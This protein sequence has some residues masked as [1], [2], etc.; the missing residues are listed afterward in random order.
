[1]LQATR[2]EERAHTSNGTGHAR[3]EVAPKPALDLI[4][5]PR[6]GV[7]AVPGVQPPASAAPTEDRYFGLPQAFLV[8]LAPVASLAVSYTYERAYALALGAPEILVRVDAAG[9]LPTVGPAFLAL[10]FGAALLLVVSTGAFWRMMR[11]WTTLLFALRGFASVAHSRWAN[12]LL[13]FGIC[14]SL[15]FLPWALVRA[16]RVWRWAKARLERHATARRTVVELFAPFLRWS[17]DL[18]DE[19]DRR[20]RAIAVALGP[21]CA[22]LAGV[23]LVIGLAMCS[24]IQLAEYWATSSTRLPIRDSAAPGRPAVALIRRYG[25]RV[26]TAPIGPDGC[27]VPR[28][29]LM[30][31]DSV[32][33]VHVGAVR[34]VRECRAQAARRPAPA[35]ARQVPGAPAGSAPPPRPG[36]AR[37][38]GGQTAAR[39]SSPLAPGSAL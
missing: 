29:S 19:L 23:A 8:A 7:G 13:L 39:P 38:G 21:G 6:Q 34:S 17:T 18:S 30:P 25:D 5:P 31:V 28:F 32:A 2:P 35:A 33:G 24:A 15:Y 10:V 36:P 26:L 14:A 11:L 4:P 37:G 1:M 9:V 27:L 22:R 12:G 16:P 20:M 3:T